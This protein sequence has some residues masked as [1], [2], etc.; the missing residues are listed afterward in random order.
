MSIRG[1]ALTAVLLLPAASGWAA[2]NETR[3][4][5]ILVDGKPAGTHILNIKGKDT[6]RPLPLW[7]TWR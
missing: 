2:D 6:P 5:S 7:P 1:F 3:T 4:F